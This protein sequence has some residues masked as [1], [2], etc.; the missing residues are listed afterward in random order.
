VIV[1]HETLLIRTTSLAVA[2]Q[3]AF[4]CSSVAIIHCSNNIHSP[5]FTVREVQEAD[6]SAVISENTTFFVGIVQVFSVYT[7]SQ[8]AFGFK[9]YVVIMQFYK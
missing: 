6:K 8:L 2:F 3:S 5:V 7:A 1:F 4:I 9:Q